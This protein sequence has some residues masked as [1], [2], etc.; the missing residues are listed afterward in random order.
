MVAVVGVAAAIQR[1]RSPK[2]S[3][4]RPTTSTASSISA[5]A[6]AASGMATHAGFAPRTRPS[7]VTA[8][9]ECLASWRALLRGPRTS[10]ASPSCCSCVA[11]FVLYRRSLCEPP[12]AIR[13]Q[14]LDY[15]SHP[16]HPFPT[17][18]PKPTLALPLPS[19]T[20]LRETQRQLPAAAAGVR[21]HFWGQGTQKKQASI[22]TR[23]SGEPA[24]GGGR[25]QMVTGGRAARAPPLPRSKPPPPP[26]DAFSKPGPNRS[27]AR[28]VET[29]KTTLVQPVEVCCL[30]PGRAALHCQK[31]KIP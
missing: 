27:L 10:S 2:A 24:P 21:V 12:S 20:A 8:V 5:H 15:P 19:D 23:N 28:L 6:G 29:V 4:S 25:L 26:T 13:Q 17:P 18:S 7:S 14:E 31:G 11:L 16:P 30:S 22:G 9:I 3:A 1:A